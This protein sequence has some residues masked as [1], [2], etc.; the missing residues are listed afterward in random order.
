MKSRPKMMPMKKPKSAAPAMGD[1]MMGS[2]Y[3]TKAKI[4]DMSGGI[5]KPRYDRMMRGRGGRTGADTSSPY[6]SAA[7]PYSSAGPKKGDK[8]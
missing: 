7:S 4:P 8:Y 3:K 6:S 5:A 2:H 1:D